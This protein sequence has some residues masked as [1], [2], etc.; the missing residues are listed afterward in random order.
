MIVPNRYL[1]KNIKL[2]IPLETIKC[3]NTTSGFLFGLASTGYRLMDIL[4][5]SRSNFDNEKWYYSFVD[6]IICCRWESKRLHKY[7]WD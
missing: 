7:L 1:F 2:L 3:L 4:F 5:Y 6:K